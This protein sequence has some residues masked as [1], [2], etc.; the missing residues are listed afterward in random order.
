MARQHCLRASSTAALNLGAVKAVCCAFYS[1]FTREDIFTSAE[2]LNLGAVKIRSCF[3]ARLIQRALSGAVDI[4]HDIALLP[5]AV[6]YSAGCST[7]WSI[8]LRPRAKP[9]TFLDTAR[10]RAPVGDALMSPHAE[11]KD[12]DDSFRWRRVSIKRA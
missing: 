5:Q 12:T 10:D 11:V 1:C 3:C 7:C 6:F 4:V 9:V 2:A 8:I